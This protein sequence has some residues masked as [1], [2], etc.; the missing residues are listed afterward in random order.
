MAYRLQ[1]CT[2]QP[3][4]G[5]NVQKVNMTV[6]HKQSFFSPFDSFSLF[7]VQ[8]LEDFGITRKIL[9]ISS[10]AS[11]IVTLALSQSFSWLWKFLPLWGGSA[12]P[13]ERQQTKSK[14][15]PYLNPFT[16]FS[17]RPHKAFL[18]RSDLSAA[19][20][21]LSSSRVWVLDN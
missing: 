15:L 12:D 21:P 19:S 7:I 18:V 4:G 3:I 1:W 20:P 17:L 2:L 14:Y 8:V 10:A 5:R 9:T 13:R 11:W 16:S 6:V